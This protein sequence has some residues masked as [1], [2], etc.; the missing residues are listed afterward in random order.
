MRQRIQRT[1]NWKMRTWPDM[2]WVFPVPACMPAIL[3]ASSHSLPILDMAHKPIWCCQGLMCTKH[4]EGPSLAAPF[5]TNNSAIRPSVGPHQLRC[6]ERVQ[7][8]RRW[9][10]SFAK[11]SKDKSEVSTASGPGPPSCFAPYLS[12]ALNDHG[13]A[14]KQGTDLHLQ[15]F[16]HFKW[17]LSTNQCMLRSKFHP[18]SGHR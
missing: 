13:S 11:L 9:W 14:S 7:Q 16:L 4:H 18:E 3:G 5:C 6:L 8:A 2:V 10:I 1:P 17:F 12:W 15:N